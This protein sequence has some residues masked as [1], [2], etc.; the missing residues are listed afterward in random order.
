MLLRWWT[1]RRNGAPA[2][3]RPAERRQAE[4]LGR[5]F[6][7]AWTSEWGTQ[8]GRVNSLSPAGCY[9]ESRVLVP[10]AG[11]TVRDIIITLD[12][13]T[14]VLQGTAVD[15][16]PGVGFAVR[17]TGLDAETHARLNDLV[18]G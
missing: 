10:A 1:G 2:P 9:I 3:A 17:F 7:C 14:I 18:R 6:D 4:R 12:D 13:G 11:A 5:Y 16:M 15:P 8:S